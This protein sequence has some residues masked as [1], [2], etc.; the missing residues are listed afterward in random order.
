[1]A[2]WQVCP[3]LNSVP[4][5][6][7]GGGDVAGPRSGDSDCRPMGLRREKFR[8]VSKGVIIVAPHTSNWDFVIG[9]GAMLALDLKL[10][11]LGKHTLS[12]V[13]WRG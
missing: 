1:M 10:R 2:L 6:R 13:L 4:Q 5:F 12:Q 9:A 3:F 8:G 11:F 7:S